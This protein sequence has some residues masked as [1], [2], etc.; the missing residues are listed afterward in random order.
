MRFLHTSDWH[1]GR[2]FGPMSLAADQASFIDWMLT[3][4]SNEQVDLVVIAGDLYD[5][6]IPP[7]ESVVLMR[8]TLLRL[9]ACGVTVVAIAGNHDGA[10]RVSAYDG[11][12]DTSGV[13][14]RG[15][16]SRA[17]AVIPLE[18]A[19]GPLDIV[20]VPFLDP[21]LAPALAGGSDETP[22][23]RTHQS[24]LQAALVE[25][26]AQRSAPRAIAVAHAF[27]T[28]GEGSDSERL[29]TVGGTGQVDISLF[30]GFAYVALGHLHRPQQVGGPTRRYSGTPLPY[31]FSEDHPK[32]VVIVDLDATGACSVREIEVPV[33]R[34]V[35]TISGSMESLLT[36]PESDLLSER[37]V[38]AIITDNAQVVD[39]KAK[40]RTRFPYIVEVLLSPVTSS[41]EEGERLPATGR[42]LLSPLD[43]AEAFWVDVAEQ[44]PDAPERD[45]LEGFLDQAV[46]EAAA[47]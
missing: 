4:V 38:R 30:D 13:Y 15:G 46:G 1:L 17:G 42:A 16:Y 8:E 22:V 24:V 35:A 10:D 28:G 34:A 37:F 43:A 26:A 14:L 11:L 40:L 44:A 32:H 9:R 19:D 7:A 21:I 2:S 5:R 12:I 23:R 27:V 39:A 29:L 18:F 3:V 31:S 20:A 6:A 47:R 45:L 33:G 36:L 25:A 41:G